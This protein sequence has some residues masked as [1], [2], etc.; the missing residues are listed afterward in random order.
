MS[1]K[2]RPRV[3][4]K[5]LGIA[6][7]AAKG[8]DRSVPANV[9][10][11]EQVGPAL[12]SGG[13][14]ASPQRVAGELSVIQPARS[15]CAF[16]IRATDCGV[17]RLAD[18]RSALLIGRNSGPSVKL[19]AASHALRASTGQATEPRTMATACPSAS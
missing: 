6:D 15:Q 4:F 11:L 12:C 8:I 1:E 3:I 10:H 14:K 19:A 9:H 7:V 13:K 18:T 17:R 2:A 5:N 16:T